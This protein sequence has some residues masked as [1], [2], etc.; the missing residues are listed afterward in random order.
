MAT[1]TLPPGV[2]MEAAL[3]SASA[4]EDCLFIRK[5]GRLSRAELAKMLGVHRV[6]VWRWEKGICSPEKTFV[7]LRIHGW[8][9]ALRA[10]S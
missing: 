8:A 1:L 6:E 4:K 3:V 9:N 2:S 10:Q 5:K 7:A